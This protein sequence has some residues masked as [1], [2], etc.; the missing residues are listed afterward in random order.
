MFE[1]HDFIR[2]PGRSAAYRLLVAGLAIIVVIGLLAAHHMDSNGHFVTGMNNHVGWGIPHVFAVFLIVAASGA[3]N[4]ASTASV[5]MYCVTP[6]QMTAVFA[7]AM[8]PVSFRIDSRS[9]IGRTSQD[10]PRAIFG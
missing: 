8:A 10:M 4:V 6:S 2:T 5:E 7:L 9:K 1:S 3:L